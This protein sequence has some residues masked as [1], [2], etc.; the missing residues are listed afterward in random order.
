MI[1]LGPFGHPGLG[2]VRPPRL[3][4]MAVSA[5]PPSADLDGAGLPARWLNGRWD[6]CPPLG[7]LG[8]NGVVA[9]D[10]MA[11]RMPAPRLSVPN[12]LVAEG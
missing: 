5:R 6:A 9:R 4:R 12:S 1:G 3:K 2:T 11:G 8:S 10:P 7:R